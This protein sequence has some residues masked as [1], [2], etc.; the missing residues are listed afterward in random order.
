MKAAAPGLLHNQTEISPGSCG[1][2]QISE[3]KAGPRKPEE[4]IRKLLF[5]AFVLIALATIGLAVQSWR[6]QGVREGSPPTAAVT[7]R[8]AHP[9]KA[10]TTIPWLPG[11]TEAYIDAPIHAQTSG[12]LKIWYFDIGATV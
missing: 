7:V 3:R 1:V 11:Q 2:V 9:R 6:T 4:N 8:V 12:Y 10:S 5:L